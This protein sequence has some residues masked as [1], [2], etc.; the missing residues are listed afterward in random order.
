VLAYFYYPAFGFDGFRI[1]NIAN[2][3]TS[4]FYDETLPCIYESL[5][6]DSLNII[7]SAGFT[8]VHAEE[9][10][11]MT[12]SVGRMKPFQYHIKAESQTGS[13]DIE[14]NTLKRPLI[15]AD[16]GFL[17][18]G[19]SGYSYYYS[20]TMIDVNGL[21]GF[22]SEEDSISG[23]AW[24]DHQFGSFNP[25]SSEDYEWFCIQLDNGMDLNIWNIF[26]EDNTIPETSAFRICSVYVNDSSSL[27]FSDF[28]IERLEFKY[29]QDGERCYSQKWHLTADSCD[30]DLT[31]KTRNS[32][33]EV[34]L[35]FRFYEGS[36]L[37]NG[38][39]NDA[40][41]EG[42]GF[43]ELLHSYEKPDISIIYPHSAGIWDNSGSARWTLNNPDD[44]NIMHYNMEISYDGSAYFKNIA[45]GIKNTTYYWNP[46]YFTTDTAIRLRISGYSADSTLSDAVEVQAY[47]DPLSLYYRS[48]QGD[49]FSYYISLRA[50]NGFEY[51]WQKDSSDIPGA[52]DS[53]Y[54]L[55]NLQEK[56]QGLYRC[57]LSGSNRTDTTVSYMLD[58]EPSYEKDIFITICESDSVFAGGQWQSSPG[59][60]YDTLNSYYGCDSII[61]TSLFVNICNSITDGPMAENFRVYANPSARSLLIEFAARF[62]GRL[63][64]I[65]SC[66]QVVRT[67]FISGCNR[68]DVDIN[69]LASGIYMLRLAGKESIMTQK[70][71]LV[72]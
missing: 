8:L 12:D 30:I 52:N 20:Q 28:D 59:I 43:A 49:D 38:T 21:I 53:I 64:I 50:G 27:T 3:T 58:I 60:F 55:E 67:L 66:G 69:G 4:E 1:F 70:I 16:S 31:I 63:E 19:A 68:T 22:L 37:V 54:V 45:S 25:N 71:I 24:I 18:Q 15:L 23:T 44:G 39:V 14:C 6:A 57:I 51:Q 65:N 9:W 35:P 56:D 41:V 33:N 48:C 5:A 36:I 29:T 40:P 62:S 13:V 42:K 10:T 47:I 2:E 7:A 72:N 46:S 34:T 32:D 26:A 17:Y 11:T 61:I